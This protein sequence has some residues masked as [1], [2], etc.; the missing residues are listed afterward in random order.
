MTGLSL[1][2]ARDWRERAERNL[3]SA[4]FRIRVARKVTDKMRQDVQYHHR[5]ARKARRAVAEL[6]AAQ[7][8]MP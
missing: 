7:G 6:L 5:L 1:Y 4:R 2:E 8:E 3:E